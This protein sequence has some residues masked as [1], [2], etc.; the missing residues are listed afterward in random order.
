MDIPKLLTAKEFASIFR[1]SVGTVSNWITSQTIPAEYV[2]RPAGNKQGAR[3]LINEKAV[4]YLMQPP[5]TTKEPV[6]YRKS[7]PSGRNKLIGFF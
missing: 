1:V 7:A 3:V 4:E 5:P 6:L 2:V